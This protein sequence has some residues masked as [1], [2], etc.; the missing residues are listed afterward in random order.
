M[1]KKIFVIAGE[2]SGDVIGAG[3][4][5]ALKEQSADDLEIVGIGGPLMAEQG[6]QS[7]VP[8]EDLN[9]MGLF[10]VVKHL[11]HILKTIKAV[12]DM[13]E[14][15]QPDILLTIDLP[16]FNHRVVKM[17]KKRET[18]PNMRKIHYVAPTVWAWRPGRAAKVAQLYDDVLCLFPFEPP[19]FEAHGMRA[20]FVGHPMSDTVLDQN[21]GAVFRA[22]HE[23]KEQ[24]QVLG[25]LFGSRQGEIDRLSPV[26]LDVMKAFARRNRD[27]VFVV[28][29]VPHLEAQ[30]RKLVSA[31]PNKV[32]VS[33][34]QSQ[35][36]NAFQSC[37]AAVAVSG[38]VGLEL[39][40]AGVPHGIVYKAHPITAFIMRRL[41]LTKYVHLANILMGREIVPEFLQEKCDPQ[42]I[43]QTLAPSLDNPGV[44]EQKKEAFDLVRALLR[45]EKNT[46]PSK[47]AASIILKSLY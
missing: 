45:D 38:T 12:A 39:A 47:K 37:T 22:G 19:Y 10:E 41:L 24:D 16:D 7:L 35:K 46:P 29:C 2:S 3:V 31:C 32:I 30:V 5:K 33:A 28:P 21:G 25:I 20:H 15:A 11:P 17:L 44:R 8:M 23:L 18:L 42:T 26:L 34:D 13:V 9:F 40:Y 14:A 43:V 4:L 36:W 6:L 1:S 27:L